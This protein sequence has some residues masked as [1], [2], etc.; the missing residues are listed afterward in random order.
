M[1]MVRLSDTRQDRLAAWAMRLHQYLTQWIRIQAD[2]Q[3]QARAQAQAKT[4]PAAQPQGSIGEASPSSQPA[5]FNADDGWHYAHAYPPAPDYPERQG[6]R[7]R[8]HMVLE[9]PTRQKRALLAEAAEDFALV[10]PGVDAQIEIDPLS[11]S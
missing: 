11:Q 1:A 8:W 5:G 4:Q 3:A 10:N 7:L 2:A 6:L 9:A